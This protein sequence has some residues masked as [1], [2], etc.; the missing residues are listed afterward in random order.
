MSWTQTELDTCQEAFYLLR[1]DVDVPTPATA[2]TDTTL[3][4][5][6]CQKAFFAARSEVLGVH[7]W[8]F[9]RTSAW[10]TDLTHW[11]DN[12]KNVLVYCLAREL[13]IPLTGRIADMQNIDA[14]YREKLRRAIV[15]D[16]EDETVENETA[17]E[18]FSAIRAYYGD[19]SRLPI[20]IAKLVEKVAAV[21]DSSLEEILSAHAWEND[22]TGGYGIIY[23]LLQEV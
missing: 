19:D 14:L 11:P 1:Q 12:I 18:V 13:A 9:A 3:E 10:R 6:K 23:N 4:W 2:D 7:D 8:V 16:L 21:E 15:R 5:K 20:S 17:R 22:V